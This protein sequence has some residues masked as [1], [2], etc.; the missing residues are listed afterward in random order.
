LELEALADTTRILAFGHHGTMR[1][2]P[3]DDIAADTLTAVLV[4]GTVPTLR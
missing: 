2:E 1:L 3:G 4:S